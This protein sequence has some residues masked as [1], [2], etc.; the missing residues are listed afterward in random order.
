MSHD[1]LQR[2]VYIAYLACEEQHLAAISSYIG[3]NLSRRFG[4]VTLSQKRG[5]WAA[6]GDEHKS[7]YTGQI[8]EETVIAIHLSVLTE[9]D[10]DAL[11]LLRQTVKEAI[12][13]VDSSAR[14]L[15]VE[16]FESQA[17][18]TDLLID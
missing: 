16:R 6:D 9:Q 8:S 7:S 11:A 13:Q 5:F 4:G 15:H 17:L 14:H 1:N 12:N 2:T 18:H 3:K 10:T